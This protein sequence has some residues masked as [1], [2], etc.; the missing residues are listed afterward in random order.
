MDRIRRIEHQGR[1]VAL[2]DFSGVNDPAEWAREVANARSLVAAHPA[3]GTLLTLTDVTDVRYD[4]EIVQMFREL[5]A[6]NKPY[7]RAAAVITPS[8]L[9][10]S[11][12]SMVGVVTR[13]KLQAF[14]TRS[15]AL[16]WLVQ[17][18]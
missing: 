11:V 16:D 18:A 14:D 2:L 17:Q 13:R 9:N 1:Q 4:K 15:A 8:A 10:R 3:N 12:I 5:A 6:H 7:V